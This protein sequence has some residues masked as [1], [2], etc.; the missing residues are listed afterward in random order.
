[1]EN[2]S[3]SIKS[4]GKRQNG[5]GYAPI[6]PTEK[7]LK[8]IPLTSGYGRARFLGAGHLLQLAGLRAGTLDTAARVAA[9]AQRATFAVQLEFVRAQHSAQQ[10]STRFRILRTKF[11]DLNCCSKLKNAF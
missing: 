2:D 8:R 3:S 1:M 10:S 5:N 11:E 6:R 4:R 7:S 9:L